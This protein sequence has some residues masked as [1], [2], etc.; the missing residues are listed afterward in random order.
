VAN[1]VAGGAVVNAVAA[2]TGAKVTVVDVGVAAPL[3]PGPALLTRKVR[4]G[5]GNI[6]VE[7]AMTRDEA[8]AAVEVGIET[9]GD[10]VA[11]GY[12]C[13]LTGDM[14]IANTTPSAALVAAFTGGL[15]RDVTGRGTG[16][17][18]E[19]LVRKDAVVERAL[20][21][22]RPDPTDPVGVLPAVRASAR[23]AVDGVLLGAA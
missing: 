10:L 14:G 2:Q 22:H 5:T 12:R 21:L 18:D 13:L 6:A 7:A 8:V 1:F 23:D 16:V 11:A 9:A 15:A 3:P 4:A 19:T 17:D 20:A